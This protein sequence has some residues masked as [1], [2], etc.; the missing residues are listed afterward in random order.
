MQRL[1][2]S[3]RSLGAEIQSQEHLMAKV[4]YVISEHIHDLDD[5][6]KET[7]AESD[8]HALSGA[9]RS[10]QQVRKADNRLLKVYGRKCVG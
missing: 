9:C 5:R 7:G 6:A 2:A 4:E 10:V 1:G 3:V 8:Y